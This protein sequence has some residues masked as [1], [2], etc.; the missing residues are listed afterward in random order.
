MI[1]TKFAIVN[2]YGFDGVE[3]LGFATNENYKSFYLT[4]ENGYIVYKERD[5]AERPKEPF[6]RISGFNYK[7][8]LRALAE[9]LDNA[10][11]YPEVTNKEKIASQ[12]IA[13]ERK[14]QIDWL[15]KRVENAL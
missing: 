6:L 13:E 7:E 2:D 12:A 4:I 15:R 9:A 8:I 5:E 11:Y 3:I 14:E 10:G 1:R